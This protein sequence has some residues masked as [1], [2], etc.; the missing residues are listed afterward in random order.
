MPA[1]AQVAAAPEHV[2][3]A[4]LLLLERDAAFPPRSTGSGRRD[5][6]NEH[7]PPTHC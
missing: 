5:S 2:A 4:V 3:I 6:I 7:L 1:R